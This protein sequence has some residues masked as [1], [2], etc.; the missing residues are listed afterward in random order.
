MKQYFSILFENYFG[1][2]N[3]QLAPALARANDRTI[4]DRWRTAAGSTHEPRFS[5]G[6]K[7]VWMLE[8]EA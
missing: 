1:H 4:S 7:S 5:R 8:R 3:Q 6:G 2:R